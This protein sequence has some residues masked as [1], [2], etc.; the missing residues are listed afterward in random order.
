MNIAIVG[1]TGYIAK[2]LICK[3]ESV[4]AITSIMRIDRCEEQGIVYLDLLKPESFDY[5]LLEAV[6]IV[7]FTAAISSPDLCSDHFESSW[8]VNVTGTI[9]FIKQALLKSCKVLFFSSDAV[10]GDKPSRIFT[11]ETAMDPATPYGRM[12]H[13]VETHF[14]HEKDVKV[15]RLSYV[16]S[17]KDKFVSYCLQCLATGETAQIYHPF[18]RNCIGLND[19]VGAVVWI[20]RYWGE[21]APKVMHATGI[22]LVSRLRIADEINRLADRRLMYEVC[23]PDSLFFKNRPSIAHMQSI[24]SES[25]KFV[26]RKSFTL[27]IREELEEIKL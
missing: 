26:N 19:V 1:S 11:E 15:I 17:S 25:Y 22:E 9:Y 24:Y 21:Y 14:Q 18:Y 13:A 23:R 2:T 3:M 4:D 12:K 8:A 5:D 16:L 7:I 20:C 10:F 27:T 6:D